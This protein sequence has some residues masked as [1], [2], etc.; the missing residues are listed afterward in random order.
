M[1]CPSRSFPRSP[2]LGNRSCDHDR[3]F[4][5]WRMEQPT[6]FR[7]WRYCGDAQGPFVAWLPFVAVRLRDDGMRD[8]DGA[9]GWIAVLGWFFY[10][11]SMRRDGSSQ[12]LVLGHA[13]QPSSSSPY[14]FCILPRIHTPAV[15]SLP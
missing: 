13:P 11:V 10:Y 4:I 9:R 3:V 7:A 2:R 15:A 8:E 5:D 6:T 12:L 1:H 14:G